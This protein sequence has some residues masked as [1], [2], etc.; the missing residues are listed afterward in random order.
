MLPRTAALALT[1]RATDSAVSRSAPPDP[2]T[3]FQRAITVRG[4]AARIPPTAFRLVDS[5]STIPSP[6]NSTPGPDVLNGRTA[7]LSAPFTTGLARLGPKAIHRPAAAAT[8][9]GRPI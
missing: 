1:A 6:I 9:I 4:S 3:F 5:R 2:T 8:A 7:I